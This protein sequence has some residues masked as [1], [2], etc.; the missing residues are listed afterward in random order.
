VKKI[1]LAVLS[2]ELIALGTVRA[3][4]ATGAIAGI[5]TD[6]TGAPIPSAR[7]VVTNKETGLK[8]ALATGAE[9]DYSAPAL[10]PG[11]YEVSAEAPGFQRLLREAIVEAGNTTTVNLT[12]RLG[13]SNQTANVD[14][15]SPQIRYDT[16]EVGGVVTRPQVEGLPLNG[17]S[18]LELAKLEPGAQPPTRGSNNRTFVPV[19]GQTGGNSGRG[20]RV[21]VDGGSIM[22][23]GN[24]GSA[25]GFSQEVVQEF[26]ISTVNFDLTTGLTDGAS[27]NVVTRS[28]GNDLHGTALYFFR[29]HN[30]AAYPALQRDPANPNPFFQRRQ[31]G[32]A[33]GGPVRRDR[34][35]FFGSWERNEQRSV[36]PTTLFGRDFAHFSRITANPLFGDQ[37]SVRVDG[38][39]SNAHTAFVRYSHDGSQAFAPTTFTFHPKFS[40][41]SNWTRQQAWVDQSMLGVTSVLRPTLVNDLRFSYFFI[42]SSETSPTQQ[43]CPGCLGIGAPDITIAQALDIGRSM[44]SYNLGRRFHLSDSLAWQR[45]THR[46]RFGVDWEHNRG[47]RVEPFNNPLITLFTPQQA[48][49]ANIPIP[50]AFNT[51][52]DI[53]QL[54][55]QTVTVPV[56]DDP[57]VPQEGGGTVR[58][59]NT[60][61]LYF[62]DTWRL[63]P[64]MTVN[65][66]LGWNIDRNLNYD[67]S[68]P[69]LLAPILGPDGLGP[70]RK[71]WKNFSPLLGLAWTPSSNGKTVIRAGAGIFYDFLFYMGL[72]D[73]RALLG[74][75]GLGQ[76]AIPGSSI[77]CPVSPVCPPGTGLNFTSP[78]P[79][80]GSNLMAIL[81]AVRADLVQRLANADRSVQTIQV[82]KTGT[83]NPAQVPSS[84]ALHVNLGVQRE[85]APNF[86]VSADFAYRHFIHLGFGAAI[87]LNH[88][89]STRGPVIPKCMRAQRDD[90]QALCSN[91]PFNVLVPAGRVTYKGL[92]LRADKRLSHGF[93]FLGSYAYSSNTGTNGT[94]AGSGFNLDNWFEN[95]GPVATDITHIGNLAGVAQLPSRFELGLNFSILSA[96]PFSA[97]VGE[98]DFNGDGT[99]D[100]LLPGSTVNAFNRSMGRA[101]LERLI[102]QFNQTYAGKKDSHRNYIPFLTLPPHYSFGHNF[103]S[104]DLRL[105][106][107]LVFGERWRLLLIG[108]VFNLYNAANLSGYSGD[109]TNPTS[110][111][112]PTSR[113]TQVFGSGGPRAFQLGARLN[114]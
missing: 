38:R 50:A 29:D 81:P 37:L 16:N 90:P 110:F 99:K 104:L 54:P 84:S 114:F 102:A 63:H 41:P 12:L 73:E 76:Q 43:D 83:L 112:Q 6:P 93:Q 79:F 3:Q 82:T 103:Q 65:Y 48:R 4:A 39:I 71:E 18:F 19:L 53:L 113:L 11:V 36:V 20:T 5:V 87:D 57:R 17:R 23:I 45:G 74:P 108:E 106:R 96:P 59:W 14:A 58:N 32:F 15:A 61:R 49:H 52:D 91:G 28:G 21:T 70:T 13:S 35:F 78:T 68:K 60:L 101:D 30:L 42:S 62:Q 22:A 40:Y 34:L 64:R 77:A 92:L 86:V 27:V 47:G 100:D 67:L 111:G 89:D 44:V 107:P 25:M 33:L 51:V 2:L 46:T 88:F 98:I 8:R 80:T 97:Y 95:R 26:Q 105:S 66:G 1:V 85:I 55:L 69:A 94:G 10:L 31:F 56:G 72:D 24:G 9:G 109:L 75:P 7:V